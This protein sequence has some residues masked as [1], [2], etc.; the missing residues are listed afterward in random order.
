MSAKDKVV[1]LGGSFAAVSV[2]AGVRILFNPF[3]VFAY[4]A[5]GLFF[6]GGVMC[7]CTYQIVDMLEKYC[8][9]P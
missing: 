2:V 8:K 6:L 1:A 3:D 7:F 5:G 9:C 4:A